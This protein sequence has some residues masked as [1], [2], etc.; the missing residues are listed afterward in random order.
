MK[1][2]LRVTTST[3]ITNEDTLKK[4]LDYRN[5]D[6][7]CITTEDTE[8]MSVRRALTSLEFTEGE[9]IIT[10]CIPLNRSLF[11]H[12]SKLT[13]VLKIECDKALDVLIGILPEKASYLRKQILMGHKIE[14]KDLIV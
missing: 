12:C 8:L 11:T 1:R 14:E 5:E 9:A 3:K 6:D 2:L 4:M 10:D 7:V 13:V